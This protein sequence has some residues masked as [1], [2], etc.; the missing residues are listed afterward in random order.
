MSGDCTNE[1]LFFDAIL[2][3]IQPLVQARLLVS[4][5][6]LH[7]LQCGL[8][9]LMKHVT[10]AL[11]RP[12]ATLQRIVLGLQTAIVLFLDQQ[13]SLEMPQ[14]VLVLNVL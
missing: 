2:H 14:R 13:A 5:A 8:E 11:H 3:F 1:Y 9:C 6:L 4:V 12:K 7:P 10:L